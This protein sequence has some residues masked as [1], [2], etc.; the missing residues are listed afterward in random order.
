MAITPEG[1]GP[2]D[3]QEPILVVDDDPMQHALIKHYLPNRRVTCAR[4]ATE[5]LKILGQEGNLV[6]IADLYM[7]EMDGLEM[8][9][10]IKH[11]SGFVQV[12]VMTASEKTEDL[13]SALK[14]GAN[15]FLLKP[16]EKQPLEDALENALS[17]IHRWKCLLVELFTRKRGKKGHAAGEVRPTGRAAP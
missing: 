1:T 10:H 15:D 5:A 12:I 16:L 8:L 2:R 9:R 13:I 3:L 14:A 11:S 17:R 4:S 6:V 7:P